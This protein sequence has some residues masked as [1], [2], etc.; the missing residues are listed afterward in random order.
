MK[1]DE[2]MGSLLVQ[3]NMLSIKSMNAKR[4]SRPMTPSIRVWLK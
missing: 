4:S 3:E 1:N 2:L